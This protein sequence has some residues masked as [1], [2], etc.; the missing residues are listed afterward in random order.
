MSH[1]SS[2]PGFRI[3]IG[4]MH[5]TCLTLARAWMSERMSL[6]RRQYVAEM[7]TASA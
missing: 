6:N 7:S 3:G 2:Y 5:F 1:P 4:V